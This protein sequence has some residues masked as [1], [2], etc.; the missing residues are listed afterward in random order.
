L[1]FH[2]LR[3]QKRWLDVSPHELSFLVKTKIMQKRQRA[4]FRINGL[5]VVFLPMLFEYNCVEH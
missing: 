5:D 2:E 4:F 3:M 1:F